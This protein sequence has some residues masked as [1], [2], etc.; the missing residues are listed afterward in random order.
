MQRLL[1]GQDSISSIGRTYLAQT[2]EKEALLLGLIFLEVV[3]NNIYHLAGNTDLGLERQLDKEFYSVSQSG[4][5]WQGR[6]TLGGD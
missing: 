5:Y 2:Y 3:D 4:L 1:C 6:G